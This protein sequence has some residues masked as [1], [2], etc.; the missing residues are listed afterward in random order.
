M[1]EPGVAANGVRLTRDLQRVT[2]AIN[3]PAPWTVVMVSEGCA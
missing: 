1:S 3:R 2:A